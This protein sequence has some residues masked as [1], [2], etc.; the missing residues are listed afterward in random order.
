MALQNHN[1]GLHHSDIS[2]SLYFLHKVATIDYNIIIVFT[3]IHKYKMN[4]H[5][6]RYRDQNVTMSVQTIMQC[7]IGL[8]L[9][10]KIHPLHSIGVTKYT[11]ICPRFLFF[12][13]NVLILTAVFPL[14]Y[15]LYSIL[16]FIV[17]VCLSQCF[18]GYISN[19]VIQVNDISTSEKSLFEVPF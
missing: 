10:S 8:S 17:I 7:N 12:F 11:K 6:D 3:V 1:Q 5:W 19:H 18:Q 13:Y 9:H 16:S 14:I 4:K 15:S 2:P